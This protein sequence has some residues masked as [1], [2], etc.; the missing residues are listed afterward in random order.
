MDATRHDAFFL[1]LDG[2]LIETSPMPDKACADARV[3]DVVRRLSIATGGA[4]MIVSGRPIAKVDELLAMRLPVAGQHGAE[5]RFLNPFFDDVRIG[6]PDCPKVAARCTQLAARCGDA[7]VDARDPTISLHLPHG[8]PAFPDLVDGMREI[9]ADSDGRLCCVVAHDA[10]ELRPADIHKGK[11][12]A[13]A[14]LFE[15]FEGRRPV[16]IGSDA[17]DIDGFRAAEAGGGF[18]V[19]VGAAQAGARYHLPSSVALLDALKAVAASA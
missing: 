1:D 7:R 13:G 15:P 18:G 4:T 5:I 9:A 3:R 19:S 6:L 10:V 8:H 2:T 11:V 14:A 16:F 17:P 12:L